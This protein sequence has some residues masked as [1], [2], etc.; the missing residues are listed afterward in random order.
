MRALFLLDEAVS[1]SV[2]VPGIVIGEQF[3][4][5]RVLKTA[6]RCNRIGTCRRCL[7]YLSTVI[8]SGI[9]PSDIDRLGILRESYIKPIFSHTV[10]CRRNK[11]PGIAAA[12]LSTNSKVT[13]PNWT[14]SADCDRQSPKLRVG[15]NQPCH[16]S[17]LRI[18]TQVYEPIQFRG[19]KRLIES[20]QVDLSAISIF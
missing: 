16:D 10:C 6:V 13:F 20:L 18:Q 7:G 17:N 9:K 1:R 2:V 19:R 11:Q 15:G 3:S 12:V 4:C 14:Q 8:N 5:R